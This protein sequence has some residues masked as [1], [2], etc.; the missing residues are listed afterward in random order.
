MSSLL[1]KRKK[2]IR[3]SAPPHSRYNLA[4]VLAFYKLVQIKI[5]LDLKSHE[6]ILLEKLKKKSRVFRVEQPD[7]SATPPLKSLAREKSL[8]YKILA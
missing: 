2:Q 1:K 4:N 8:F 5:S 3:L 6:R 7:A